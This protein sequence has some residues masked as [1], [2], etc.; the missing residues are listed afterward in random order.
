LINHL[1]TRSSATFGLPFT[2]SLGTNYV[3]AFSAAELFSCHSVPSPAIDALP[4][5][6]DLSVYAL[7]LSTCCPFQ[8]GSRIIDHLINIHLFASIDAANSPTEFATRYFV[9]LS[10]LPIPSPLPLTGLLLTNKTRTPS[11]CSITYLLLPS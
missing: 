11:F 7:S 1:P 10:P 3:C 8:L 6:A 4:L 9:T 5:A 2:S